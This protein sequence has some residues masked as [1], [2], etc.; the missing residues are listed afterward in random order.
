M[1]NYRRELDLALAKT[2]GLAFLDPSDKNRTFFENIRK[3]YLEKNWQKLNPEELVKAILEY[4]FSDSFQYANDEDLKDINLYDVLSKTIN[5]FWQSFK[6]YAQYQLPLKEVIIKKINSM[7]KDELEQPFDNYQ[8]S[9]PLHLALLTFNPDIV[10]ALLNKGINTEIPDRFGETPLAFILGFLI[11]RDV[12]EICTLATRRLLVK[13]SRENLDE[14]TL[15]KIQ[16]FETTNS[17]VSKAYLNYSSPQKSINEQNDEAETLPKVWQIENE[18]ISDNKN[19]RFSSNGKSTGPSSIPSVILESIILDSKIDQNLQDKFPSL[20]MKV[21]EKISYFPIIERILFLYARTVRKEVGNL[22]ESKIL[23]LEEKALKFF[24]KQNMCA[25]GAYTK[26]H[27]CS[28]GLGD[29]NNFIKE[30]DDFLTYEN[31]LKQSTDASTIGVILHEMLHQLL[32][33][34]YKNNAEIHFSDDIGNDKLVTWIIREELNNAAKNL[35]NFPDGSNSKNIHE[36]ITNRFKAYNDSKN[37][38]NASGLYHDNQINSEIFNLYINTYV[39]I[40]NPEILEKIFPMLT[41]ILMLALDEIYDEWNKQ[42]PLTQIKQKYSFWPLATIEEKEFNRKVGHTVQNSSSN[43]NV[44]RTRFSNFFLTNPVQYRD[45]VLTEL[46]RILPSLTWKADN[47]DGLVF[48]WC[49][50]EEINPKSLALL[51]TIGATI[52]KTS[53]DKQIALLAGPNL[54]MLEGMETDFYLKNHI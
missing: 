51:T 44:S 8:G 7:S 52:S 18:F 27:I 32:H 26:R 46:N 39:D 40:E 17:K 50:A 37:S 28:V 15:K 31:K 2:H 3:E 11:N 19:F 21:L 42:Y 10:E 1:K 24:Y 33:M 45:A 5:D 6:P 20:L 47:H 13:I 34:Y 12:D 49:I 48:F 4:K 35:S 23:I 41:K 38:A 29:S 54:T 16:Q 22:N 36:Q 53:N 30:C 14:T 9:T 43:K 25:C